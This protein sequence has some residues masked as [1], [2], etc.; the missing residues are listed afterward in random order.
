[1]EEK[2][3]RPKKSLSAQIKS[4]RKERDNLRK[5]WDRLSEIRWKLQDELEILKDIVP[6]KYF[7][8]EFKIKANNNETFKYTEIISSYTPELAIKKLLKNKTHPTTFE[9]L[10]IKLLA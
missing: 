4:L 5:S 9:L 1:M 10:D 6:L 7:R 2:K 8:I 3:K